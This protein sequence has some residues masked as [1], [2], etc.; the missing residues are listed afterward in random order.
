MS[1]NAFLESLVTSPVYELVVPSTKKKIKYRAYTVAE[2]QT[3][4]LAKESKDIESIVTNTKE[5]IRKCTFDKLDVDTL[6][7]FDIEYIFLKLRS[8][9]VGEEVEGTL[10]CKTETCPHN[11]SI[12]LNLND[13]KIPE[14]IKDSNIIQLKDDLTIIMKYPGF[15]ALNK[16]AVEDFSIINLL[17]SLIDS[18]VH[19]E[20][21]RSASEFS[22]KDLET[23]LNNMNSKLINKLTSYIE[24]LPIIEHTIEVLCPKCGCTNSYTLKGLKNFF[25]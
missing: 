11:I 21:V 16:L 6:A 9:S 1:G 4:L 3:L 19:K 8:V 13:V 23:F 20:D 2:E 7:S 18:I 17:A 22:I 10:K 14:P 24:K 5:I 15:E 25:S 12:V